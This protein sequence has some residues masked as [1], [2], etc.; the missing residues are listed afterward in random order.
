ML[1]K[2]RQEQETFNSRLTRLEERREGPT[3]QRPPFDIRNVRCYRCG[4]M[5]HFARRCQNPPAANMTLPTNSEHH[6]HDYATSTTCTAVSP[7]GKLVSP[8]AESQALGVD[9]EGREDGSRAEGPERII[10]NCPTA[11]I[12]LGGVELWAVVDTGSQV[13]TITAECFRRSFPQS[14]LNKINWLTLSAANGTKI[15]YSGYF[16]TDVIIAGKEAPKRGILVTR[17]T[18][19]PKYPVLLGMNV[20]RQLPAETLATIIGGNVLHIQAEVTTGRRNILG[21]VRVAG[22][23]KIRIPAQSSQVIE[24]TGPTCPAKMAVVID[25]DRADSQRPFNQPNGDVFP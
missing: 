17:T 15:P 20:L 14:A 2:M 16:E 24:V 5:G 11:R 21:L 1:E 23:E 8:R 22:R 13:T 9:S 3:E 19:L 18:H 25:Q 6:Q 12:I 4:I 7:V 10:G